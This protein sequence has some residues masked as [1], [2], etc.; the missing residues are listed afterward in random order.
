MSNVAR[1]QFVLREPEKLYNHFLKCKHEVGPGHERLG[2]ITVV[3]QLC[4]ALGE[5]ERQMIAKRSD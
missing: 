5:K 3:D 1:R 4:H 2:F